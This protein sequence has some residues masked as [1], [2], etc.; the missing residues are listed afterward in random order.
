MKSNYLGERI[1]E[2]D[3]LLGLAC[4]LVLVYHIMPHRIPLGWATVDLFFVLSGY[5]ITSI[6]LKYSHEKH[7]LY[8]F[9]MR[10]GLR[11]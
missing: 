10:R 9:Y 11:I 6:I 7:F 4:L 3:G 5:L 2:L 8:H 1:D